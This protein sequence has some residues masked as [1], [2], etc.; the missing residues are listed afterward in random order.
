MPTNLPTVPNTFVGRESDLDELLRLLVAVR[1]VTL[2]GTGGIG[3]TRL[4][5]SVAR[6]AVEVFSDGVWLVELADLETGE[7]LAQ[8]VAGVLGVQIP[9]GGDPAETVAAAVGGGEQLLVLDN[10][11]HLIEDSARLCSILL[12]ACPKLRILATSREPLRVAGETVWRVPPLSLVP[13]KG[14]SDAVKLF[15]DRSMAGGGP[16]WSAQ[17][18][19][20]VS[21]LCA[22]LEGIPLAI[23]L[24]AAMTRV[25]SIE[26]IRTRLSDRFKLLTSGSRSAPARQRTLLATVE[27]SYRMLSEPA[28]L[29][30]RRLTVFRGGWT[31][32]LAELV[33]PC[34]G[35]DADEVLT[36]MAELVDKSLVMADGTVGD[37]IRYRMLDTVRD[38]ARR[39]LSDDDDGQELQQRHLDGI[40]WIARKTHDLIATFDRASWPAITHY[41]LIIDAMQPNIYAALAYAG[42]TRQVERGLRIFTDLQ[43]VVIA[44]GRHDE[45]IVHVDA[46]LEN[47]AAQPVD[48][49]AQALGIRTVTSFFA[50]DAVAVERFGS[51][52]VKLGRASGSV[53]A[54]VLGSAMLCAL[55]FE[56][57]GVSLE[58]A[59]ELCERTGDLYLGGLVLYIKALLSQAAGRHREAQRLFEKLME[60]HR[61]ANNWAM[62]LAAVGLA[63]LAHARG[64][65]GVAARHYEYVQELLGPLDI[66]GERIRCLNGL[67]RIA[68]ELGDY[69]TA[70]RRLSESLSLNS[71]LGQRAAAVELVDAFADLA[72]REGEHAR[73][74]R[75][76]AAADALRERMGGPLLLGAGARAQDVLAPARRQLG[77]AMAAQLWAEGRTL[78]WHQALDYALSTRPLTR[79]VITVAALPESTLTEREREIAGLIARGLSNKAL[80]DELVISPAT[81]ARHV[82]NILAKL[83]FSSRTQVA[84]WA[85]EHGLTD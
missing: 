75:L 36:T 34:D 30:L 7:R 13:G 19:A 56:R 60:E 18:E 61:E 15:A 31:L 8:R 81:V 43:W 4:C 6:E 46:L 40:S 10:C 85:I 14:A 26:Q 41:A 20:A 27:W 24:A 5:L 23:E 58:R 42:R 82:S 38:Y 59:V 39:Q 53:T 16:A 84:T 78:P 55:G 11:E 12:A 50:G 69:E 79:S 67:G 74:V 65:L 9:P 54:E 51:E 2:C 35:L 83:G 71:G 63:Q 17:D 49:V 70:R 3:K 48:L 62:A 44:S 72:L 22:E 21:T 76:V 33:C 66:R 68:I 37:A 73:A 47:S 32:E 29:L 77:D 80:A 1:V 45:V 25:L 64:D 28:R 57:D 52:A